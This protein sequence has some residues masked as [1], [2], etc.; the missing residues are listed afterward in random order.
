MKASP[1]LLL[2]GVL[3][4]GSARRGEV[5]IV[6]IGCQE[7]VHPLWTPADQGHLG[8]NVLDAWNGLLTTAPPLG[9]VTLEEMMDELR[10]VSIGRGPEPKLSSPRQIQ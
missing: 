10:V 2:E 1:P 9:W 3:P 6:V 7:N 8:E 5:N 4:E